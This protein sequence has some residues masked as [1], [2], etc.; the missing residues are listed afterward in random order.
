MSS[1]IL[2]DAMLLAA[3]GVV[4]L[5]VSAVVASEDE[6]EQASEMQKESGQSIEAMFAALR[7]EAE[8]AIAN[9][10][11]EEERTA[12]CNRIQQSIQQLQE[13]LA[14]HGASVKEH[15]R[16]FDRMLSNFSEM[17]R[18]MAADG[19]GFTAGQA[20]MRHVLRDRL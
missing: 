9:C 11:T 10:E 2:E 19:D 18:A 12:V 7:E 15:L 20:S 14:N 8:L 17:M 1:N 6:G 16:E 5:I 4:G 13:H 3:G